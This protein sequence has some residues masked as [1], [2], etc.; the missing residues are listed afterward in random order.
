VGGV[1]TD[2]R[3]APGEG[4]LAAGLGRLVGVVDRLRWP[5]RLAAVLVFAFAA[6]GVTRLT[7]ETDF[8]KNFRPDSP[9][10]RSLAFVE[11][12]LGGAGSWEINFPAPPLA[13]LDADYL[14]RVAGLAGRLRE[15]DGVT[16]VVAISDGLDLLP[17]LLATGDP[18]KDFDTIGSLQP[19][20]VP[21][22]YRPDEGRMR[23][24]LRSFERRP[25]DVKKAI[26]DAATQ[27]ARKAFPELAPDDVEATG[28]YVLLTFLIDGLL[29]DQ[30]TSFLVAAAGIA[31][32]TAC[33]VGDAR[34]GLASLVPN[35][36]PILLVVGGLGWWGVPVNI[37]TAMIA[38]VSIGLTIDG[39]IHYLVAYREAIKTG[40]S[41]AQA[42]AATHRQ[43]GRALVF[44]TIALT[45]GF[46]VLTAS[47]FIPL[48]YFGALTGLSLLGGLIGNL[49]LL[50]LLV[51]RSATPLKPE[52]SG[53]GE[54]VGDV[55]NPSPD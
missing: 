22:L 32:M 21:S 41:P 3:A 34:L 28:L 43:V 36:T 52:P 7:V 53:E 4:G 15:I 13:G 46:A 26:I 27:E 48:V 2:P 20:F 54:P 24:V 11:D 29:R 45:A 51:G 18:A 12:R 31:A 38:S 8:S 44:A 47:R 37:G 1:A 40:L 35:V 33:A 9:I 25:A 39:S 5:I 16:K 10:V 49:I 19:E 50:P 17:G 23:I 55:E 42:L 14:D 6:V 30:L